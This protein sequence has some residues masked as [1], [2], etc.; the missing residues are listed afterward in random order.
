MN[1]S[2]TTV[3][4]SVKK[5]FQVTMSPQKRMF[6]EVPKFRDEIKV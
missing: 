3:R 2:H 4:L 5:L 6:T 1:V